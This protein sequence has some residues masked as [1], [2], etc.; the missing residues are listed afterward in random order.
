MICQ[1]GSSDLCF[2]GNSGNRQDSPAAAMVCCCTTSVDTLH[3]KSVDVRRSPRTPSSR[4]SLQSDMPAVSGDS[5]LSDRRPTTSRLNAGLVFR[6][7][8]T[9]SS[10]PPT[11]FSL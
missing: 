6:M 1:T 3:P 11:M 9:I 10:E 8:S 4:C 5:G 7:T 2:A